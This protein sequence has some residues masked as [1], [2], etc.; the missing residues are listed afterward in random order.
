M[1]IGTAY[2]VRVHPG[3]RIPEYKTD[4]S[5]ACDIYMPEDFTLLPRQRELVGTGLICVP[6]P[7]YYWEVV[8]R[9]GS[10]NKYPGLTLANCIGL[11]DEDYQGPADE[12][13]LNLLNQSNDITV[14]WKKGERL[15]Q[16]VLRKN[17]RPSIIKELS[18]EQLRQKHSRG[19]FG[20]TGK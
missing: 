4:L 3:A 1:S 9:S 20:S 10:P 19:G 17:I 6:P 11:I 14:T 18:H 5:S 15:C 7:G 13:R 2:F 12:L 8:L 16:L